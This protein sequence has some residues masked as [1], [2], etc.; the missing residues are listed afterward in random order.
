LKYVKAKENEMA[1]AYNKDNRIIINVFT[2][3]GLKN[4]CE[5]TFIKR[6]NMPIATNENKCYVLFDFNLTDNDDKGVVAIY[7]KKDSYKIDTLSQVWDAF[8]TNLKDELAK[9]IEEN[10]AKLAC[11]PEDLKIYYIDYPED[12]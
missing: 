1:V 11:S 12:K 6:E 8:G 5:H 2:N 3:E 7:Y 10:K 4:L 9:F